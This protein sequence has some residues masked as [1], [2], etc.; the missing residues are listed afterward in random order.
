MLQEASLSPVTIIEKIQKARPGTPKQSV[1]LAL[2][3]LKKKEVIAISGKMVSLHEIWLS[4]MKKF[5]DEAGFRSPTENK[6]DLLALQEKEYITYKFNSLL[7]LDMFWAHAVALFMHNLPAGQAMFLYNPH[8]WFLIA[9][10]TSESLLIKEAT[11][12]NI[13]W[14]HL[15]ASKTPLDTAMRKFFDGEKAQCHFLD[16][17]IFPKNYYLNC[18][19]DYLIEVWLNPKLSEEIEGFYQTHSVLNENSIDILKKIVEKS[20]YKHKM[21]ISQNKIKSAKI[22][23]LFKKYFLVK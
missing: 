11:D 19:G 4:K 16:K 5:F 1:Y 10:E 15:I 2:R 20:G 18:L 21:K 8:E 6:A 17:N 14:M 7:S 23:T 12:R 3:K 13:F 22:R 9:R